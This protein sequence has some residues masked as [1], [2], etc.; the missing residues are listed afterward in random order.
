MFDVIV[1][2]FQTDSTRVVSHYPKGEGGPVFKDRTKIPHDY[3]ALTH[4]GLPVNPELISDPLSSWQPEEAALATTRILGGTFAPDAIAAANDDLAMAVLS[5]LRMAGVPSPEQVS[6]VGF[7]DS[8]NVR[9]HDLGFD[10]GTADEG[11]AVRRTVNISAETLSLTTV[12]APFRELGRRAV[13]AAIRLARGD[14]VP[15]STT[16]GTELIVRRSCG[17]LPAVARALPQSAPLPGDRLERL[18][19]AYA[20]EAAGR[21]RGEFQRLLSD[22]VRDSLRAG[23]GVEVWWQLLETLRGITGAGT[24]ALWVDAQMLLHETAQRHWRYAYVL[25]EKRNQI[26]REVGQALITAPDVAG[27]ADTLCAELPKLGIPG[28]YLAAYL[29][30]DPATARLLLAYERGRRIGTD[31]AGDVFRSVRLAPG[32]RVARLSPYS[33]VVVPFREGRRR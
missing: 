15:A 3:H 5:M 24:D 2:A 14:P 7:D 18:V 30:D 32:D 23:E 31:E 22:L 20:A 1:L 9:T 19:S 13:A 4:H 16:I 29:G 27:L 21:T 17:C 28:C 12:R 6:V 26:V 11:D 33:L 25:A 10:S 8:T